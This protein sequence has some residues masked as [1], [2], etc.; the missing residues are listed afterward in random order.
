MNLPEHRVEVL[1]EPD[2]ASARY[3]KTDVRTA[4]DVLALPG[5]ATIRVPE[6]LR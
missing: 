6:I 1:S 2:A 3:G 5:G 4:G